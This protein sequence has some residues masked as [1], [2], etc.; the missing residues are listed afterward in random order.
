MNK[1]V[2]FLIESLEVILIA[3]VIVAPIRYFVFQPFIVEGASMTPALQD[4]DY[5]IVD[6]LSY[7]FRNPKRGEIIIFR[8]PKNPNR[9]FIKR[10]IGMPGETITHQQGHV[11]VIEDNQKKVLQ[12]PYLSQPYDYSFSAINLEDNEYFMIGD[13]RNFSY[14]SRRWGPITRSN[15]VGRFL[16]RVWPVSKAYS[17]NQPNYSTNL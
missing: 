11:V 17:F 14:D 4:S 6:E 13:N 3:L 12:E 15:I 16:L 7:R 1:I 5:L 9:K 10:V 8:Y 2:K